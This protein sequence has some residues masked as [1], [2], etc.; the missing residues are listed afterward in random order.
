AKDREATLTWEHKPHAQNI[1]AY[2]VLRSPDGR[3]F[4]KLGPPRIFNASSP[5]GKK[6]MI[7]LTDSLPKNYEN[8]WYSVRGYDAFGYYTQPHEPIKVQGKDFTAPD[9]PRQIRVKQ[10]TPNEAEIKWEHR[11]DQVFT[12]FQVIGAESELGEYQKLHQNPLPPQQRVFRYNLDRGFY[13]YYRVMAVDSVFNASVSDIGYLVEVDTVPPPIPSGLNGECDSSRVIALNWTPSEADDIKG[14]RVF[15]A[16]HPS[17]GFFPITPKPVSKA[18]FTD[19]ISERLE[20]KVYYRVAALDGNYNHSQESPYIA[21][22]IPDM[23]PPTAPLLTEAKRTEA[24][25]ARLVWK[26]SSHSDVE[27]YIVNILLPSDSAYR[28]LET[29]NG[30]AR[31]FEDAAFETRGLSPVIY[32]VVAA[33]SSGNRSEPSNAMRVFAPSK[34]QVKQT[35]IDNALLADNAVVINWPERQSTPENTVLIYRAIGDEPFSIL[36]RS[37]GAANYT[38][39]AVSSGNTY[40]YK[41]GVMEPD[42]A[43]WALSKEVA[44]TVE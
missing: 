6:G 8:Y 2:Q 41:L 17:Q 14:Y 37:E 40:R 39:S 18:S 13:K 16:Y 7:T 44:V 23:I 33:D 4:S 3:N 1:V 26:P 11:G 28:E 9:K 31:E 42:G 12:G 32:R 20:K 5:A 22:E 34:K 38:D 24:G 43:R 30:A 10:I 21:V 19:T 36:E 29:L 15:K 35:E 25:T 27:T